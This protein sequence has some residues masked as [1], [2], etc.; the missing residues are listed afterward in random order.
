MIRDQLGATPPWFKQ[1][2][3]ITDAG[4]WTG[5]PPNSEDVLAHCHTFFQLLTSSTAIPP[6]PLSPNVWTKPPDSFPPRSLAD[7]SPLTEYPT[8]ATIPPSAAKTAVQGSYFVGPRFLQCPFL[9]DLPV[10]LLFDPS[11]VS[12]E[13]F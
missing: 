5:P 3:T 7:Y 12:F 10:G 11:K 1:C 9:V 6:D 2:S 13:D 8:R 4:L